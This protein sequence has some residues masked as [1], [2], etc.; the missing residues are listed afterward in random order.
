MTCMGLGRRKEYLEAIKR[1][2]IGKFYVIF[3]DAVYNAIEPSARIQPA[4]HLKYHFRPTLDA[5]T[6]L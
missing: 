1:S 6:R 5:D 3:I 2:P 4:L